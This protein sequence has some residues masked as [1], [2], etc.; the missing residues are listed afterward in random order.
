MA[1]F[2]IE[3]WHVEPFLFIS[4]CHAGEGEFEFPFAWL[5]GERPVVECLLEVEQC[6]LSLVY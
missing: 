4:Q 6:G 3:W 1:I 2:D 5:L